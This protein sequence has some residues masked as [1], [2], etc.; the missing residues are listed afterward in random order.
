MKEGKCVAIDRIGRVAS[1]VLGT[2]R[3][4]WV[5]DNGAAGFYPLALT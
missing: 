3:F 2:R 4:A 5:A 1:R